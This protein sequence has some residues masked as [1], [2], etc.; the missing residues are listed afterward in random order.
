MHF[1]Y[2]TKKSGLIPSCTHFTLATNAGSNT[3]L[4]FCWDGDHHFARVRVVMEPQLCQCT[5]RFFFYYANYISKSLY[6][7]AGVL[8]FKMSWSNPLQAK[9]RPT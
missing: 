7:R 3:A 9:V 4:N 6:G 8:I 1:H 5:S 2:R